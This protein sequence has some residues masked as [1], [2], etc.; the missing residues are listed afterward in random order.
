MNGATRGTGMTA[1]GACLALL[2][3]MAL[4]ALAPAAALADDDV[5]TV[6]FLRYGQ[7]PTLS[8][9]DMAVL[10]LLEEYGYIDAEE[11]STLDGG[12]DLHGQNINILYRDAGFDF[13]TANLMVEDALDE[14]AD[15]LLTVSNEV[16]Q[17]AAAAIGDMDDPPALIFAIVTAPEYVGI[18]ASSCIK[19]P[20]VTGTQMVFDQQLSEELLFIQ[21]PD[22]DVMGL[23]MDTTDPAQWWFVEQWELYAEE[24]GIT[25]EIGMGVTV[26]DWQLATQSLMNAEVD[27]IAV[28]PR[29]GD[30]ARG[31]A[32]VVNEAFG[33]P[34]YS[35]I[36]TDVFQGVTI[37]AGFQ[38]WYNEGHTAARILIGHLRGEIDIATTGVASHPALAIAVNMDTAELQDVEISE[39]VLELADYVVE[40]GAGMGIELEIPGLTTVLEEMTLDERM[41][42]DAEFLA[43]LH[44]TDEMIAEQQ[45]ALDAAAEE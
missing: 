17:V 32:A 28:L 12:R 38:G 4:C 39:G 1:R 3:V 18:V 24:R 26:S 43:S 27:A 19:P 10:D 20:N 36:V 40:G 45:A 13:A 11:R 37:A 7:H 25:T 14:G 23:L 16:G 2:I 35:M 6:A 44:C 5:P 30:P 15:I 41:A 22:L 29:T 8:L 33:V 31:I 34:L 42:A 9:V 21:D